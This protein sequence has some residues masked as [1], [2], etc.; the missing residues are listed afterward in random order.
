MEKN[1]KKILIIEDEPALAKII[2]E[3]L[4]GSGF[5]STIAADGEEGLLKAF[6]DRPDLIILDLI[7]PK[8]DGLVVMRELREDG[9]GKT[10][11]IIILTNLSAD[12]KITTSVARNNPSYY[13]TKTEWPLDDV[14]LK[15]KEIL[16]GEEK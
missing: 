13:L 14:V 15:V 16:G 10:V 11:P 12:N 5:D 3:K 6:E 1:I 2:S 7:L 4:S 9:W 8:K